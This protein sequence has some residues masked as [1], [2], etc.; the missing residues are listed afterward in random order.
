M[1]VS[2]GTIKEKSQYTLVLL[3]VKIFNFN[4]FLV[5]VFM[6]KIKKYNWID[7]F[8]PRAETTFYCRCVFF[9]L[10]SSLFH[11]GCLIIG[12]ILC[13][14]ALKIFTEMKCKQNQFNATLTLYILFRDTNLIP[15]CSSQINAMRSLGSNQ[16][17][18]VLTQKS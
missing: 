17:F 5:Q 16:Q 1:Y 12:N 9:C 2:C 3:V 11:S 18:S 15:N 6:K 8:K 13:A 4:G 7:F 10:A 14:S